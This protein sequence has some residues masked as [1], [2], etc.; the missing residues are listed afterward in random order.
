MY[1]LDIYRTANWPII[2]KNLIRLASLQRIKFLINTINNVCQDWQ[3]NFENPVVDNWNPY[4]MNKIHYT[5]QC[6]PI[7]S[8][9]RNLPRQ[10]MAF[11]HK[12]ISQLVIL[13]T[14]MANFWS[15]YSQ[16]RL[17]G[18]NVTGVIAQ[19]I[20]LSMVWFSPLLARSW[21]RFYTR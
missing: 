11:N 2:I 15:I 13:L 20:G 17:K 16:I 6:K 7:E 19:D 18:G 1:K 9:A 5:N 12:Q 21:E 10:T 4:M 14:I 3:A 8:Q